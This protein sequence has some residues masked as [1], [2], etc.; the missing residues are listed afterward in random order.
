MTKRPKHCPRCGSAQRLHRRDLWRDDER[1]QGPCL[2]NWHSYIETDD[3]EVIDCMGSVPV[4]AANGCQFRKTDGYRA[5]EGPSLPAR[6]GARETDFN[7]RLVTHIEKLTRATL[8]CQAERGEAPVDTT[9]SPFACP[10]CETNAITLELLWEAFRKN[11]SRLV[12]GCCLRCGG[13]TCNLLPDEAGQTDDTTLAPTPDPVP[14][15]AE[16][17]T[18]K[19]APFG[20]TARANSQVQWWKDEGGGNIVVRH[21]A[22]STAADAEK[23]TNAIKELQRLFLP[24]PPQEPT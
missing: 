21:T 16:P 4:C 1:G 14:L 6:S 7:Q 3:R 22:F 10:D 19:D 17:R 24:A 9:D 18:E 2:D 12:D 20:W 11:N 15:A 23:F 13:F 8:S 5:G